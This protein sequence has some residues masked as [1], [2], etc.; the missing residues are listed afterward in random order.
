MGAGR[1]RRGG[2][3]SGTSRRR[4][5]DA[6]RAAASIVAGGGT[7]R[8]ASS[9]GPDAGGREL[10]LSGARWRQGHVSHFFSFGPP[11]ARNPEKLCSRVS[12]SSV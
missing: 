6:G 3:G 4:W 7:A 12:A 11:S 2:E 5:A 8:E 1:E 9:A 10:F